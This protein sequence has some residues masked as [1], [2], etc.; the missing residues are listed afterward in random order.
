VPVADRLDVAWRSDLRG[1]LTAPTSADGKVFVSAVDR[2]TVHAL[3]LETGKELWSHIAG[4]RVDSPPTY[5][6]GCVYFGSADGSMQCLRA[7][8]G[9]LVWRFFAAPEQ[10]S[11]VAWDQL[12]SPWPVAGSVLVRDGAVYALAG[13][14]SNLDGGMY[15]IK[16]DARTGEPQ[17]TK[18]I[19]S[20]DPETGRQAEEQIDDLYMPGLLYDIPSSKGESIFVRE[21]RLSLDGTTSNEPQEHL[22]SVG[23]FL[24]DTWWHRYYMIYGTRFKNGPGGGL[25]RSGGAPFGRLL[26]CDGKHVYGYGRVNNNRYHLFCAATGAVKSPSPPKA[27][28]KDARR[29]KTAPAGKIWSDANCPMMV[30]AMILAGASDAENPNAGRLVTAGPPV[31]GFATTEIL[32]GEQGGLLGVVDASTGNSLSQISIEAPPVFDGMCAARG[33]VV[34]S[35]TSGAIVCLK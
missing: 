29:G 31:T 35:L 28:S 34:L 12:E 25:G 5:W 30:R 17:L 4:G 7:A 9:E 8:D 22:Y 16:L 1:E 23:G 15:F 2:H 24:D 11:I 27:R 6:E 13:R 32:H 33:R 19:Y 18:Q 3:D 26:V 14:S 20:R 21:A 10:A